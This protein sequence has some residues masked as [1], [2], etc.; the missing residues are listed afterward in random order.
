VS[1]EANNIV[2]VKRTIGSMEYRW[3]NKEYI[4]IDDYINNQRISINNIP[5]DIDKNNWLNRIWISS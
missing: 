5:E 3:I 2:P 1:C 4:N